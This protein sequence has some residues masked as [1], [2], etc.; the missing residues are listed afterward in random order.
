MATP[1]CDPG[2]GAAAQ[3]EAR[4]HASQGGRMH[5]VQPSIRKCVPKGESKRRSLVR[6]IEVASI[7]N[8]LITPFHGPV[9]KVDSLFGHAQRRIRLLACGCLKAFDKPPGFGIHPYS[10]L[11]RV[12]GKDFDLAISGRR[13]QDVAKCPHCLFLQGLAGK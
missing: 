11:H 9:V 5:R 12:P 2:A 6:L 10:G 7:G 8:P 13:R 3:E 4:V 1:A